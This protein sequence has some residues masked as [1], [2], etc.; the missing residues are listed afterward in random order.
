MRLDPREDPGVFD[1]RRV[2]DVDSANENWSGLQSDYGQTRV[3]KQSGDATA[4]SLSNNNDPDTLSHLITFTAQGDLPLSWTLRPSLASPDSRKTATIDYAFLADW[5]KQ[6][7][8]YYDC[9]AGLP[10]MPLAPGTNS[11]APD[12]SIDCGAQQS[13]PATTP[14]PASTS[15]STNTTTTI[16]QQ[17]AASGKSAVRSAN[18]AAAKAAK[19]SIRSAKVIR[20]KTGKRLVVFVRSTKA[21]A[22]IQIRMYGADGREVGSVKRTVATN[23]SVKVNTRLSGKVKTVKVVLLG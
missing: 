5:N 19:S 8:D 23:R 2:N 20:S 9:K 4:W 7:Q 18:G 12:D 11:P 16:V 13:A 22:R 14:A 1:S 10:A 15:T 6:W 17:V 21:T 3:F